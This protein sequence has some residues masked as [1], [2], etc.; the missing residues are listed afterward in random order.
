M[1]MFNTLLIA[2][3]GEIAV[4][5]A[6]ACRDLGVRAVALYDDSD[7]GS[8][9]VRLA[10]ACVR[11]D[12]DALYR[13]ADALIRIA[14][15]VGA[16]AIHPGYGFLAEDPA[17]AR[18][19]AAAG[20]TFVGAPAEV[21]EAVADK[22]GALDRAAAAGFAVP[23]HSGRAFGPGDGQALR[24]AAESL[25]FPLLVKSCSGGRSHGT[26]LVRNAAHL[27]TAV[28]NAQAAAAVAFGD[29]RVYLEQAILPARAIEVQLAGDGQGALV[30]L[31]ERDASIQHNHRKLLEESPAPGLTGAQREQ[32]LQQAVAIGRLFACRSLCT[33][34]FVLDAAGKLFFAE[35]KARLQVEH[36]LTELL[37]GLDLV[38]A[39]IRVA[40]GEPLL[41]AQ[42]DI[43]VR[44]V[45]LQ[46]RVNAE[47]PWQD[48]LPSP[49]VLRRFRLPGGPGVRVDTY[50]YGGCPVSPR[51][52]PLL[53]KVVV[54]AE[55]RAQAI[56]RMRRAL[57]DFAI[58]GVPTNLPL[59][60]RIL[61]HPDF[62]AGTYDS[63]FAAGSLLGVPAPAGDLADLAI[64]A[65]V[66][67]LGQGR[68]RPVQPE[69]TV[70]TWHKESRR[71]P[72]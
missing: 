31:G 42:R 37:T 8:L 71:L 12:S 17:F 70:G 9:H 59:V 65:A 60:Q 21:L 6:R 16:E 25:G 35:I 64:A 29:E 13:D 20:L 48:F 32:I 67:Y 1:I 34:E 50:A 54:V 53:A 14:K 10:D 45:A 2:N 68:G 41:F 63:E 39:Q 28:A 55:D 36:P 49:G 19:C 56:Q 46:C 7:R 61:D 66:A 18:A 58:S 22:I 30:Q 40:A 47:D 44:G 27:E 3:R 57:E 51:F 26:R 24:E 23:R 33:V 62:R 43:A 69:R 52:D 5:I 72:Q 15:D 4:R 38:G 11:L